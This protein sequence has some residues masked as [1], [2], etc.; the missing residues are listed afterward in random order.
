MVVTS[1]RYRSPFVLVVYG[2]KFIAIDLYPCAHYH[3]QGHLV[4]LLQTWFK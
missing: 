1:V 3:S 4:L 2:A